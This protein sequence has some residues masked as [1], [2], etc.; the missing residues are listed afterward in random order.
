MSLEGRF[1]G[2]TVNDNKGL[3]EPLRRAATQTTTTCAVATHRLV[4]LRPILFSLTGVG[5]N[6]AIF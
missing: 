6:P 5:R 3:A 2:L 1:L 4:V